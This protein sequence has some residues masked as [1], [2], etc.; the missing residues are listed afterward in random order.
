MPKHEVR[1]RSCTS[2][3]AIPDVVT[4]DGPVLY[5][6]GNRSSN[7]LGLI[8]SGRGICLGWSSSSQ[9][10]WTRLEF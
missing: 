8:P 9:M 2:E 3:P 4:R 6:R 10:Q 7:G 5:T 1:C